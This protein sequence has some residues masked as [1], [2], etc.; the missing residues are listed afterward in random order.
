M[1]HSRIV[2]PDKALLETKAALGIETTVRLLCDPSYL[3]YL[4]S[5]V[6]DAQDLLYTL[7]KK[8]NVHG[9]VTKM[10]GVNHVSFDTSQCVMKHL[11]K[12]G[13]ADGKAHVVDI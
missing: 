7:P 5:T 2:F 4:A 13:S 12:C 3:R 11:K 6:E 10:F 9:D 8:K 1:G